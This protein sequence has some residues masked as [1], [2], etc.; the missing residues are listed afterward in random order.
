MEQM[1]RKCMVKKGYSVGATLLL[2]W[3]MSS[4]SLMGCVKDTDEELREEVQRLGVR[5]LE[6]AS[7]AHSGAKVELGR[8]LFFDKEL[9]GNRDISCGTCHHPRFAMGDGRALSVGVG[10]S[11]GVG[12]ERKMGVEREYVPRNSP[13][14][15]NL[16]DSAWRV[17]F[18]DGR[19]EQ[20]QSGE[21]K[22]PAVGS[23]LDGLESVVAAQAMFPV[24]SRDEM[25]GERGDLDI[26]G[27]PNEIA[28]AF[29]SDHLSIWGKI[30]TRV[31]SHEGY[32][33]RFL[34][35]Y[36]EEDPNTIN[37]THIA[38]AIGAFEEQKLALA[39]SPW[40]RFLKGE[41]DAL[42]EDAKRG[43][44]LFYGEAGCSTCHS[45][46][47]M[48]N[49]SYYNL[50]VPQFGPGKGANKPLDLG[51][52]SISMD[53]ADSYKFRVPSLRHVSYTAPYMHN[54]AY[55]TLRDAIRHH[56]YPASMLLA[57]DGS[58]IE[59][60]VLQK[61]FQS[62]EDVNEQMLS[63]LSKELSVVPQLS[64]VQVSE[65]EAFLVSCGDPA[66]ESLEVLVPEVVP[67]GLSVDR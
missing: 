36:G 41:D 52:S 37:F 29:D 48:T 12:P 40:D 19:V 49:Q 2:M 55:S 34:E 50:A 9:S 47:L 18:W 21:L 61:S 56:A 64:G 24:T 16:N 57:Y 10:G 27:E 46:P 66:V 43:A 31:M 28:D 23:L 6:P 1:M 20:Y 67:S 39:N 51:R 38:N 45:G 17:Q 8:L 60:V 32:R 44:R 30:T 22:S 33:E 54:G 63:S 58:L 7:G 13:G 59:D 3:G 25:R 35:V 15:F 53:P 14:L 62:R 26:H 4:V 11:D 65:L 5:S 42:S